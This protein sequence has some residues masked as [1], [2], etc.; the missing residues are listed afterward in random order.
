MKNA[1]ASSD[2]E[3]SQAQCTIC[4]ESIGTQQETRELP[5]KHSFHGE[6]LYGW[7]RE[8]PT[9]PNCRQ[10]IDRVPQRDFFEVTQMALVNTRQSVCPSLNS[11]FSES[12]LILSI[13]IFLGSVVIV[14]VVTWL[15][16]NE[17]C[18]NT[19]SS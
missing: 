3:G 7:I 14:T 15:C 1:F 9:C 8:N 19:S 18:C 4:L 10:A 17:L 2:V 13:G 16:V 5:C 11:R 12:K 6:C